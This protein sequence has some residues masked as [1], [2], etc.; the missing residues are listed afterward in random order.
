M[1]EFHDDYPQYEFMAHHSEEDG[2]KKRRKLWNVFWIMLVVTII[3]L[4]IGF[5][6]SSWGLLNDDRTS[7]IVLKV[8]FIGLTIG[9]AYFIVFSFMHLGDEK[10]AMKWSIL[11]PYTIFIIYLIG[12]CVEEANYCRVNK[13]EMDNIIVQQKIELNEAAKHPHAEGGH[14]AGGA[15]ETHEETAKP[16]ESGHH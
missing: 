7:S 15:H 4:I 6:A 13:H 16:A 11:A 2:K 10:K 5:Q 14:D 1:S 9:K 3:E 12:I 8:L